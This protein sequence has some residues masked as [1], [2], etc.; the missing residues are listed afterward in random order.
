METETI[1]KTIVYGV[2]QSVWKGRPRFFVM[3]EGHEHESL[4]YAK[5]DFCLQKAEGFARLCYK[6]H[7]DWTGKIQ[8]NYVF[9]HNDN[10][11]WESNPVAIQNYIGM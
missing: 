6:N 7:L 11:V 10:P 1:T 3:L 2:R 4:N 5:Y 9:V 8:W